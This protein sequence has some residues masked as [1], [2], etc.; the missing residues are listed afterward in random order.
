[1]KSRGITSMTSPRNLQTCGFLLGPLLHLCSPPTHPPTHP[2]TCR[3]AASWCAPSAA[4]PTR[5]LPGCCGG[6]A[7]PSSPSPAPSGMRRAPATPSDAPTRWAAAWLAVRAGR[8]LAAVQA[9]LLQLLPACGCKGLTARGSQQGA[10]SC[11]LSQEGGQRDGTCL[12]AAPAGSPL[13]RHAD[14]CSYPW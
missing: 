3:A 6:S 9:P 4:L 2:P 7:A 5:S 10:H 14:G 11:P 8:L 1:M 13:D 12:L